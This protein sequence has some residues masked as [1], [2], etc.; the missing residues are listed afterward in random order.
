V[1]A[2]GTDHHGEVEPVRRFVR[3]GAVSLRAVTFGLVVL[4]ICTACAASTSSGSLPAGIELARANVPR[5]SADAAQALPAAQAMNAFGL[6][7]YRKASSDDG[8]LV[9]SPAS[10]ALALSM[11]RAG[12][13]GETAS[14]MDQVMGAL[15]SDE[16]AAWINAIDAA[17]S[18][19][20]GTFKDADG[21]DLSV[22]LRIANASFAQRGMTLSPAYLD[23]LATR[24]G[25]G[26]DLVDYRA[27]AE[28]ARLAINAWVK[29][30]TEG[31][32]PQLIHA[33]VLDAMS[34]LVLVNA[35]YLKAP[36]L[37]PFD[38]EGT[39]PGPFIKPDGSSVQ[40]P[41][42][43]LTESLPYAAG[44]GWRA[45]ELPYVGGSLAMDIIVPDD[46]SAF[47]SHLDT[48][49]LNALTT[50]LKENQVQLTMPRFSIQNQTDVASAL[51]GLGMP[52]AFDADHADFSGMTA[53]ERLFI[54]NVI[55]QANIDVDEKG[56]T[57]AA[58]TAVVM[59]ATAIPAEP[60]ALEVDRPFVFALRDVPTG[61]IVF[62]GRVTEPSTH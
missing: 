46:L 62:L 25:A 56:T 51:A 61:A 45:V 14:Q 42:M 36:W 22:T 34:R 43:H 17:L 39:K 52:L 54:S 26:V 6:D 18:T 20:S 44:T 27:N 13:R 7:L 33:G 60:V 29:D 30:R 38:A 53:D 16:H 15:A 47:D 4:L 9:L 8:N 32:I 23:A 57:A 48:D 3:L 37:H 55:H 19:R 50:A 10:I 11:A 24:F 40:V 12:A 2:V 28:A 41:M 49:Q 5:A 35:I 21:K 58:A 1:H 31:R 59:R